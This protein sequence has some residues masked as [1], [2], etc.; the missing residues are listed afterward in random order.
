MNYDNLIT[1]INTEIMKHLNK[2][3]Y[4]RFDRYEFKI[5]QLIMVMLLVK[6]YKIKVD[7]SD[8]EIENYENI[9]QN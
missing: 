5:I 3:I 8:I 7:F 9:F 1:Q 2:T 4:E 6:M